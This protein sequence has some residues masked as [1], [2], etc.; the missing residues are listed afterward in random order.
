MVDILNGRTGSFFSF[1]NVKKK[2]EKTVCTNK[3]YQIKTLPLCPCSVQLNNIWGCWP[4]RIFFFFFYVKVLFFW[5]RSRHHPDRK[6]CVRF[7]KMRSSQSIKAKKGKEQLFFLLLKLSAC[8]REKDPPHETPKIS[9]YFI[10]SVNLETYYW[11]MDKKL[12]MFI[13]LFQIQYFQF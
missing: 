6:K 9:F 7:A 8:T 11:W 10:F 12:S 3:C 1:F 13:D 4:L 5:S 2:I